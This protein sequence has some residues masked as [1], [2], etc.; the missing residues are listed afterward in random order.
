MTHGHER[1]AE[2]RAVA[3]ALL[4]GSTLMFASGDAI[5][6]LAVASLPPVEVLFIRCVVVVLITI[7]LAWWRIGRQCLVA[8]HPFLQILR[9][10]AI[11]FS[12]LSF[13][14]GLTYLPLADNSAINFIWPVLITVM[15]VIFLGEK[16]GIRRSLATLIGFLGMLL[17]VRPGTS[18]FQPAAIFPLG[19]ALLWSIAAT[20]T[21]G[22][23]KRDAAETTLVWTSLVMLAGAAVIVYPYWVQPTA[24]EWLLAILVGSFSVL[25]HSMLVFAYERASA[26]TLAPFSYVQLV[27]ATGLGFAIFG[28]IPDAWILSGASL[29]V[30]S[31]LYTA[32][33]ERVRAAER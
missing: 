24:K 6:K 14:T 4:L 28:S 25:G 18:A 27:W 12:S 5:A 16:V 3:F 13:M 19:A 21:R 22:V 9:G 31:G 8:G 26:S 33:R 10:L 23:S 15:S 20:L 30:L 29:I 2:N 17:I 7:P 32:H 1:P 11:L